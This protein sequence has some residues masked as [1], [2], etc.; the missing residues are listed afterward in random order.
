MLR[1]SGLNA[2]AGA[3][4][5]P[6]NVSPRKRTSRMCMISRVRLVANDTRI[7]LS[8]DPREGTGYLFFHSG[9]TFGVALSR[10]IH[11]LWDR[12]WMSAIR[13]SET[14]SK[15]VPQSTMCSKVYTLAPQ[16]DTLGAT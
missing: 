7:S 10:V 3:N 16:Y 8:P 6:S 5:P 12:L 4:D 2:A 14:A 13:A 15:S 1:F 11:N 9:T